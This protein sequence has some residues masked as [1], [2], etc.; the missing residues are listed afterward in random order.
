MKKKKTRFQ[1]SSFSHFLFHCYHSNPIKHLTEDETEWQRTK[2]K[3]KKNTSNGCLVSWT[4]QNKTKTTLVYD[5]TIL[6]TSPFNPALFCKLASNFSLIFYSLF[7]ISLR[8]GLCLHLLFFRFSLT[9]V[10]WFSVSYGLWEKQHYCGELYT[11]LKWSSNLFQLGNRSLI[12]ILAPF[13]FNKSDMED[14]YY[15]VISSSF[16]FPLF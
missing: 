4:F 9:S 3:K 16:L 1:P 2:K 6:F 7:S 13:M 15:D 12:A 14:A 8:W 10:S 5:P 11:S